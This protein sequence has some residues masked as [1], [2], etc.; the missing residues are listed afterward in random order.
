ME[1]LEYLLN[2]C[3]RLDAQLH[4]GLEPEVG[5]SLDDKYSVTCVATE[6]AWYSPCVMWSRG[7]AS[8]RS[9]GGRLE[10]VVGWVSGRGFVGIDF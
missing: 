2:P 4:P 8:G 3:A 10:W 6:V 7:G 9:D 5:Y 1:G